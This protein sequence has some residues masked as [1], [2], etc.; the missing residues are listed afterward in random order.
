M[1]RRVREANGIVQDGPGPQRK[2]RVQGSG[3]ME[4]GDGG[5]GS[6]LFS[7]ILKLWCL[8]MFRGFKPLNH[9]KA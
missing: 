5:R 7:R 3:F 2:L 8:G 6:S 9:P 1:R 4:I